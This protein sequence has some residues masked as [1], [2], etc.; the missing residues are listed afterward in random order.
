MK[1]RQRNA[2]LTFST[3]PL[4]FISSS[5][6]LSAGMQYALSG[7]GAQNAELIS[8]SWYIKKEVHLKYEE[9][10]NQR[11]KGKD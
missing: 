11:I 10:E 3:S 8:Y 9:I 2:S 6:A 4:F 7:Q 1:K 5:N